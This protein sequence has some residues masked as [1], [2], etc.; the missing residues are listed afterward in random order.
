MTLK[1]SY[2]ITTQDYLNIP[3]IHLK[4][5]F[6]KNK[7]ISNKVSFVQETQKVIY[8][9]IACFDV[10]SDKNIKKLKIL[11]QYCESMKGLIFVALY[12]AYN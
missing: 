3:K 12:F 4:K 9:N 2:D 11:S 10:I 7:L 6:Q 8:Y 5:Y 1:V